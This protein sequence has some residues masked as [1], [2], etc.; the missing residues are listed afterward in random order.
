MPLIPSAHHAG[1]GTQEESVGSTLGE[2]QKW[3]GFRWPLGHFIP[4]TLYP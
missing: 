3:G 1:P 4:G 2:P